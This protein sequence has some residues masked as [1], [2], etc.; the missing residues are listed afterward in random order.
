MAT[1]G[2]QRL[3]ISLFF[4]M[5]NN[6]FRSKTPL[7]FVFAH[8]RIHFFTSLLQPTRAA[9]EEQLLDLGEGRLRVHDADLAAH[10]GLDALLPLPRLHLS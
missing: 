8:C 4:A 1:A 2:W 10:P 7:F 6:F 5:R 9:L 3:Y